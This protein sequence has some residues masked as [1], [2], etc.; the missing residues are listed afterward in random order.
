MTIENL[1]LTV[2]IYV[3]LDSI[4]VFDCRLSGVRFIL[5]NTYT[6]FDATTGIKCVLDTSNS[7]LNYT[8]L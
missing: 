4:N 2:F 7:F 6:F 8:R 3:I 1:F 5:H